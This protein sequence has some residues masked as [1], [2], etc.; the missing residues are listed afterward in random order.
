MRPLPALTCLAAITT[1][2][3]HFSARA[4]TVEPVAEPELAPNVFRAVMHEVFS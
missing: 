3:D 1:R 2:A 4:D